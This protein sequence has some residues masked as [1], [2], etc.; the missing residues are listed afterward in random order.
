M[1]FGYA[2]DP[3]RNTPT[4]C[5]LH[6][7]FFSTIF[8]KAREE[9]TRR[10]HAKNSFEYQKYTQLSPGDTLCDPISE[11]YVDSRQLVALGLMADGGEK[12]LFEEKSWG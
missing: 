4:G 12:G 1:A 10:Q 6:F 5:L 8:E 7:K 11:K 3:L 2:V 9:M